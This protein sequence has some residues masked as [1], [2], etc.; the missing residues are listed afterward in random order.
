MD[1]NKFCGDKPSISSPWSLGDF[2][3]ATNGY[4]I[5]RIPRMSDVPERRDAPNLKMLNFDAPGKEWLPAPLDSIALIT[6]GQCKGSGRVELCPECKGKGAVTWRSTKFQHNYS[7]ECKT[8]HGD[9]RVPSEKDTADECLNCGGKG[10]V[11]PRKMITV[12]GVIFQLHLLQLIN[13]LPGIKMASI[14]SY[15]PCRFVFDGGDGII[16]PYKM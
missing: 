8:C 11:W 3:Y 4:L 12:G 14:A 6:C 13:D 16:M 1:L 9:T 5:V 15:G 2:T 10:K 7:D